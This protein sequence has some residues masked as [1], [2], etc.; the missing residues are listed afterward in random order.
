MKI[1]QMEN[2]YII[3]SQSHFLVTFC[4]LMRF[5]LPKG[6]TETHVANRDVIIV[7]CNYKI[8]KKNYMVIYISFMNCFFLFLLIGFFQFW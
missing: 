3:Q 6:I 5:L 2:F 4:K 1:N 7:A 8:N